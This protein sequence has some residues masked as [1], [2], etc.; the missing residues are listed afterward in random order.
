MKNQIRANLKKI[1]NKT[2]MK[3]ESNKEVELKMLSEEKV[4]PEKTD[5]DH[6]VSSI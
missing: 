6:A 5:I 3:E 1:D 2:K 4:L